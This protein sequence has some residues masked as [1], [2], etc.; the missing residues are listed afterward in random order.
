MPFVLEVAFGVRE[1]GKGGLW[2]GL[3]DPHA[4]DPFSNLL[5]VG[6]AGWISGILLP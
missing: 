2:P 6:S 5:L 3:M 1:H 4:G